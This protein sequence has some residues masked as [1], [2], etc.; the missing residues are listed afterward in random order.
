MTDSQVILL[1]I[2]LVGG[3]GLLLVVAGVFI[4]IFEKRNLES[5]AQ[6]L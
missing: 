1:E 5:V 2:F 4:R 6:V 3:V